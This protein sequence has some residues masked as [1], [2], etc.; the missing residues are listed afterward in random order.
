MLTDSP[1]KNGTF[2]DS[3][4]IKNN[5]IKYNRG[6]LVEVR[7]VMQKILNDMFAIKIEIN[8]S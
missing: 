1:I 8:R 7:N 3:V 6:H 5:R 2:D 4:I